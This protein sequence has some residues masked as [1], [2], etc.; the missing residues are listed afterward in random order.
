MMGNDEAVGLIPRISAD[1]FH[2]VDERLAGYRGTEKEDTKCMI[3]VSYLEIYNE[4]I[5]D[6][7]NPSDKVLK[8]HESPKT[9]IYVKDLCELIVKDSSDIMRLIEQGNTVRRVAATNMNDQ[10]S[11][12]HSC[13]TVKIEQKLITELSGGVTREQVVKAKLNLVDLAGSERA[14]KT[15]ASGAT[16]KEG[17]KINL[18]LMTLGTVINTLA[19]GGSKGH[20]PY[21]DSQLTRLLQ[22]SLGGNA[23]TVMIAAIS[24][25]DYNYDETLGTLKYAN[26]AKSIE[27]VVSRNED[28]NERMIRELKE[29]IE[30]L[31]AELMNGGGPGGAADPE[32]EKKLRQMEEEQ[33]N[34]WEEKERLSQALAAERQANMN[35][36]I[37]T[38][39]RGI[40]EQKIDHMKKIKLLTIEK[41]DLVKSQKGLKEKCDVVKSE[42][43]K[44]MVAY[45]S[46]KGKYEECKPSEDDSEEVK[47]EKK[48]TKTN[49]AHEMQAL[50]ND[51]ENTK[52]KWMEKK[53]ALKVI[54]AKI[55]HT[56]ESID[57]AKADLVVAHGLLDQNDKLRQKIHDEERQKAKE[58]IAKEI[59]DARAKLDKE[60]EAVRDTIE[61]QVADE[62]AQ[63]KREWDECRQALTNAEEEKRVLGEENQEMR[64]YSERLESRL[65]DAEALHEAAETTIAS[66]QQ[67]V[68]DNSVWK[69]KY[70]ALE[71]QMESM[72]NQFNEERM[73][74]EQASGERI[75]N[76]KIESAKELEEQKYLM[77]KSLMDS[78]NEERAV[79]EAKCRDLQQLLNS[80]TKDIIFLTQQ[81]EDLLHR[82]NEMAHWEPEIVPSKPL[83][84]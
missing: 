9:G 48:E 77:F 59:N 4:T 41:S 74:F 75:E 82:M 7:L 36:V 78:F 62:M 52:T 16:L 43:D 63:L 76:A 24:P 19:A 67:E 64:D 69:D 39:M 29:Q 1:L 50:L 11:R 56:E 37:S 49:L 17:A 23:A 18:S 51:I 66:L 61:A 47:A 28:V 60:R 44:K 31:K 14:S 65:A 81:N 42:L 30:K 80:A 34:A 57:S 53:D 5:K 32:V 73:R 71:L 40:K 35:S 70:E 12:S 45:N 6:L 21:R 72:K 3:T 25:A 8:I 68:K 83:K 10:S 26:R 13:F 54:R 84:R 38:M 58:Q 27:N 2:T 33:R 46:L 79:M 22:E 55:S 20:I 15:G